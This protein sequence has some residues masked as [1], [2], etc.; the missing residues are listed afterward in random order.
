MAKVEI[1]IDLLQK[2]KENN[3]Y[4][5][6]LIVEA[7]PYLF[8]E[9]QGKIK[10]DCFDEYLVFRGIR[11]TVNSDLSVKN[12]IQVDERLLDT[13]KVFVEKADSEKSKEK[14]YR[15]MFANTA[16]KQILEWDLASEKPVNPKTLA[17]DCF[18]VSNAMLQKLQEYDK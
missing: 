5:E 6:K 9:G 18:N 10:V 1:S 8:V 11:D 14:E 7:F 13:D 2:L 16:L 15:V 12:S 4:S 17:I 3:S